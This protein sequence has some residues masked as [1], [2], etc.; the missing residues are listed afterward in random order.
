LA[1]AIS[2]C[3]ALF[4]CSAGQR[5]FETEKL[6]KGHG[7]FFYHALEALRGKAKNAKGEVT[8]GALAEHVSSEVPRAVARPP[9]F[10]CPLLPAV[11]LTWVG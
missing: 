3:A 4:S 6:G 9:A 7:V 11:T 2:G 5:A 8:W 10:P 1:P